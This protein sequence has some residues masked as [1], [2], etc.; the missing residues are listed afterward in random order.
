MRFILAAMLFSGCAGTVQIGP[1]APDASPTVI[2]AGATPG[3][4]IVVYRPS[5]FGVLTNEFTNP[6]L[7]FQG[8]ARG[9]C[10]VGAPLVL[11]VP[12]G[13]WTIEAVTEAGR[14]SSVVSVRDGDTAYIR[15]GT[16]P[17]PSFGPRPVL[18]PVANETG[19]QEAG[20]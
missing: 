5:S 20:L 4:T 17:T 15:C 3:N 13:A 12:D 6:A 11:R 18:T 14:T 1:A 9:T 16:D 7:L 19:A 10:R 8:Q 2:G